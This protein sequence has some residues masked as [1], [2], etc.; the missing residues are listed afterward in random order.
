MHRFTILALLGAVVMA[1]GC[2]QYATVTYVDQ[3]DRESVDRDLLLGEVSNM[4]LEINNQS[5]NT[6]FSGLEKKIS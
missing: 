3:K 6:K 4:R 2:D 1:A 5:W